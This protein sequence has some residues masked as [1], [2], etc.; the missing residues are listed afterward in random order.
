MR[1]GICV[2]TCVIALKS[3][4]EVPQYFEPFT[5]KREMTK[6]HST[7]IGNS[8]NIQRKEEVCDLRTPR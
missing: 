3:K 4:G 7:M 1:M 5:N 8:S 2:W 6:G